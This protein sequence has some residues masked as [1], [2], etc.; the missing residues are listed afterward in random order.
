MR[1]VSLGPTEDD[2]A[3][4]AK[5]ISVDDSFIDLYD[6][7]ILYGRSFT[8]DFNDDQSVILSLSA[9]KDLLQGED[10]AD[11]IGQTIYYETEPY[12]LVGIVD[13]ISQ[14]SL[15]SN[16]EP[17]IYT[18]HDRVIYYSIKLGAEDMQNTM[19]QIE[20]AFDQNYSNS[21]FEYFFLDDYFNRQYKSDRLFGSIVSF[22]S[23]LAIVI[24]VLGLFGLSLYNINRRSK[25]VS[26]RKVLGA[27]VRQLVL[28]LTKEYAW[29]IFLASFI[30][31]PIGYI[32]LNKWLANF[33]NHIN[34][35]AAL[36]LVPM[37][38][39]FVLTLVTVGYQVLKTANT[40]PSDSLR[41][42]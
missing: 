41:C 38:I 32:F 9:A 25:E 26:V 2:K 28:L 8:K 17:H 10:L 21:Y 20:Q 13:D 31:I 15:K 27:S 42:E 12:T 36:F 14:E 39:V 34:I 35:G 29:L 30:S 23:V 7:K 40:N 6:I 22:F 4:Y 11:W 1:F 33:A 37:L 24:T 18:H 16:I 5:D 3:L 19:G